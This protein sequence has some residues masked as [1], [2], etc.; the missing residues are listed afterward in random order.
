MPLDVIDISIGP[1][2]TGEVR[3]VKVLGCYCQI[4]QRKAD[5]KVIVINAEDPQATYINGISF[6]NWKFEIE[7]EFIYSTKPQNM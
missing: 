5:F 1:S 4:D 6:L 3:A 7:I 2:T